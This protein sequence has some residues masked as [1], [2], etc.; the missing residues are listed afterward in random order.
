MASRNPPWTRDELILALNLYF[1]HNP[2]HISQSHRRVVELSELLNRLSVHTERPDA[3]R[4]RNPNGVYM[5]LC[6]FLRFDL[7]YSGSGLTRGGKL[8]DELWN[9]F[10]E[11]QDRLSNLAQAIK[12]AVDYHETQEQIIEVDEEVEAPE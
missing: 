4:F 11:D 10:S 6:N 9:E 3:V 7:S 2:S 8:E 1:Q 5:K 12:V